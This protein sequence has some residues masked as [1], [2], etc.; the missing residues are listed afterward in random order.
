MSRLRIVSWPMR[1]SGPNAASSTR[2]IDSR[3]GAYV[4]F[5]PVVSRIE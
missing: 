3:S 2:S 1:S 5:G 4:R